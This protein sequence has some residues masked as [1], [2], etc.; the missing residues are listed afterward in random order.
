M[1]LGL[2]KRA[3]RPTGRNGTAFLAVKIVLFGWGTTASLK[4]I[5]GHGHRGQRVIP[6]LKY[7]NTFS[8]NY[9][10]NESGI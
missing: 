8:K 2:K 6:V 9:F 10:C 3:R 4:C 7:N 5:I 1:E